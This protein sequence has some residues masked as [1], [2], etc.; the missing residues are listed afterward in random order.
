MDRCL[1]EDKLVPQNFHRCF[2]TFAHAIYF[3]AM[4]MNNRDRTTWAGLSKRDSC[5]FGSP[6]NLP[7]INSVG[8][9]VQLHILWKIPEAHPGPQVGT[10]FEPLT[11]HSAFH[12]RT[13]VPTLFAHGA[14]VCVRNLIKGHFF[15]WFDKSPNLGWVF[16]PI[17]HGTSRWFL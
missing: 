11:W 15:L 6:G 1:L 3:S 9:S 2:F 16:G 7:E 8:G 13:L 4:Q 14:P 17:S 10:Y 5:F 12:G